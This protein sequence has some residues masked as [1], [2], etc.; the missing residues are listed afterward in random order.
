MA[1]GNFR[2]NSKTNSLWSMTIDEWN[3]NQADITIQM[4]EYLREK[5]NVNR[6]E[7]ERNIVHS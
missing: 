7:T 5:N 1:M 4:N 6:H 2:E 3:K